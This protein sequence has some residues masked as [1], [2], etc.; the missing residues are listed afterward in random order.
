M[1]LMVC[2]SASAMVEMKGQLKG[3]AGSRGRIGSNKVSVISKVDATTR[4]APSPKV[5]QYNRPS[6]SAYNFDPLKKGIS[7]KP[8]KFLPRTSI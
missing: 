3:F 4:P 6:P 1:S 5:L 2:A 8:K 7:G